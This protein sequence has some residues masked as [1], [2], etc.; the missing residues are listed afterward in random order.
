VSPRRPDSDGRLVRVSDLL[1]PALERIGPK[2]LWTEAKLRKVWPA[3]VG[4]ELAGHAVPGRL[5]G[6][7]LVVLVSSDTWAT[8]LRYL[9]EV[10]KERLNAR[11]GADTVTE[12]SVSK[13]RKPRPL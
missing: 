13:K 8:E 3:I 11:L 7:T 6:S 1:G 4:P 12:I 10:L 2:T 5:R 9:S